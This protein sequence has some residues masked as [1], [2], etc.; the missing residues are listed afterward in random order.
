VVIDTSSNFY[1]HLFIRTQDDVT[2]NIN[3]WQTIFW[4]SFT[5]NDGQTYNIVALEK[6]RYVVSFIY[7][8]SWMFYGSKLRVFDNLV[9][10]CFT[11]S[12]EDYAHK[13][14]TLNKFFDNY[15]IDYF[16]EC[17]TEEDAADVFFNTIARDL[18]H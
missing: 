6:D 15:T 11:F 5:I 1:Q 4:P 16:E 14:I 18:Y 7:F 12:L 2:Q 10:L 17:N 13:Q 8:M 9:S 3:G